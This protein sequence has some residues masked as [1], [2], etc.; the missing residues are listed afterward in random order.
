MGAL[1]W[2]KTVAI[3]WVEKMTHEMNTYEGKRQSTFPVR[4]LFLPGGISSRKLPWQ[5]SLICKTFA[6]DNLF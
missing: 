4:K 6:R 2:Q 5:E 3:K 1:L